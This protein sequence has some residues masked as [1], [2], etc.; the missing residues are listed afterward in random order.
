MTILDNS[1]LDGERSFSVEVIEVSSERSVKLNETMISVDID[2]AIDPN[3]SMCYD[4]EYSDMA[5]GRTLIST[6]TMRR[7]Y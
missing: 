7:H 2:I 6:E 3:D 5:P 4:K 1:I